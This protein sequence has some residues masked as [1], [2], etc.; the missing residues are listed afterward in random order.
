[1]HSIRWPVVRQRWND[2]AFL[3]WAVPPDLLAP[4]LPEGFRVDTFDGRGYVALTPF[5]VAAH[6]IGPLPPPR[7]WAFPETNLRTYVTGP[8]GR[9]GLWF[10]AID[11]AS[12]PVTVGARVGLGAPYHWADMAVERDG[13]SVRYRSR[14][15]TGSQAHHDI[16]ITAG[17]PVSEPDRT[18]LLDWL[19]GRWRS[20]TTLDLA[21]IAI[22]SPVS[23]QPWPL[24][25]ADLVELDES[26][27]S[28]AGL[29]RPDVEPMAHYAPGVDARF[30][31]SRP[32]TPH[33]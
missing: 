21:G 23:H 32:Y 2:V 33:G 3:H 13:P 17:D 15:L 25:H 12:L 31:F 6:G 26:I 20:W 14:R 8:D 28:A 1:M 10:L 27:F 29:E 5:L 30:G 19:T 7:A 18:G 22:S 4:R 16:R 9:D 24:H 11:A